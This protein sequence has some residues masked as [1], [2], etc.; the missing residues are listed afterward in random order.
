MQFRSALQARAISA[1]LSM[2]HHL[3][4]MS[5]DSKTTLIHRTSQQL[6]RSVQYLHS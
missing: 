5:V 1:L 6:S 2:L 3:N 4:M